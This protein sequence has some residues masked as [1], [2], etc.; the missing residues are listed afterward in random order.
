MTTGIPTVKTMKKYELMYELIY[1]IVKTS[2]KKY[3]LI[4]L[5]GNYEFSS[6]TNLC[7]GIDMNWYMKWF[8]V[9]SKFRAYTFSYLFIHFFSSIHKM[10]KYE[11]YE[12]VWNINLLRSHANK[13]I[14]YWSFLLR[15]QV[16]CCLVIEIAD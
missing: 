15:F 3:E 1:E 8:Y 4:F 14:I 5:V 6:C 2:M 12:N 11:K 16:A 13:S 9:C 10:K 7:S